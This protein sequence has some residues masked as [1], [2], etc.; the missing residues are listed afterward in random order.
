MTVNTNTWSDSSY[1]YIGRDAKGNHF[2]GGID[3]VRIYSRALRDSEV[4]AFRT[5]HGRYHV[6]DLGLLEPVGNP[7][8][9]KAS[10]INSR[11]DVVGTTTVFLR[12]DTEYYWRVDEKNDCA[13]TQGDV[14]SFTTEPEGQ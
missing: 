1:G 2:T 7:Q 4:S 5:T 8:D 11:G 14:W 6:I 10:A 9:S 3:D 12:P 13:I